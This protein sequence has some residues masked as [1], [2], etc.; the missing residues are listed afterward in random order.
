MIGANVLNGS[1]VQF[2]IMILLGAGSSVP[3]GIP[4]MAGFT[5]LF[6][7]KNPDFSAFISKIEGAISKS[8]DTIGVSIPFDLETLLS[9]LSDLSGVTDKPISIPT[10]SLLLTNGLSIKKAREKYGDKASLALEKL[11]KFIFDTCMKPIKEGQ[12]EGNFRSLNRFLAH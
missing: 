1:F 7:K 2:C 10:A 11:M 6:I 5:K 4:G 3:F 8:K 12:E 9:V